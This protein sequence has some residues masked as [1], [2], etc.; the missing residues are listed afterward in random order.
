MHP[1]VYKDQG[2][3]VRTE[4]TE[5][6][7]SK[8]LTGTSATVESVQV[9]LRRA[10]VP[11][12]FYVPDGWGEDEDE[13]KKPKGFLSMFKKAPVYTP[14]FTFASHDS[15]IMFSPI[16]KKEFEGFRVQEY[17]KVMRYNY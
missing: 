15:T 11:V 10:I 13:V 5:K 16:T 9:S 14:Q 1:K 4:F 7:I 2:C 8:V 6:V 3:D 12:N 17:A